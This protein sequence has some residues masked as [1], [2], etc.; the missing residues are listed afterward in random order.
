MAGNVVVAQSY[1][2]YTIAI[3]AIAMEKLQYTLQHNLENVSNES[4]LRRKRSIAQRTMRRM[5]QSSVRHQCR[6]PAKR[7]VTLRTLVRFHQIDP[8]NA[9][10]TSI[11]LLTIGHTAHQ[12]FD[13]ARAIPL[14][15]I[16]LLLGQK[17]GAA[18]TIAAV[19]ILA[20]VHVAMGLQLLLA[21]ETF[22]T[23]VTL[24]QSPLGVRLRHV[25][26]HGGGGAEEP[27]A[28]VVRTSHRC[29][30]GA[31]VVLVNGSH[32]APQVRIVGE[33]AHT[34]LAD[35]ALVLA[36]A[37]V[38]RFVLVEGVAT[39]ETERTV[40]AAV[41]QFERLQECGSMFASHRG[42]RVAGAARQRVVADVAE[43]AGRHIGQDDVAGGAMDGLLRLRFG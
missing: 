29:A 35:G 25:Q 16:L 17:P 28:A 6:P 24:V 23:V 10:A 21:I 19:R 7:Y 43:V 11:A 32:V 26:R 8:S 27:R 33:E 41:F 1:S 2:K 42:V 15:P 38:L 36:L 4:H 39:T 5:L 14:M 31:R 22:R 34:I 30:V 40:R 20:G 9:V 18:A 13:G 12:P 3:V 37:G